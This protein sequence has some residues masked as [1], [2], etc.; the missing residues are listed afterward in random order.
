M[1]RLWDWFVFLF[2]WTEEKKE[3][4]PDVNYNDDVDLDIERMAG[5]GG[6]PNGRKEE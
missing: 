5:E 1:R 6:D 4:P 2:Y 3:E